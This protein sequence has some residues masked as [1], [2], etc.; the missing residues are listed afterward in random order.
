MLPL[1]RFGTQARGS[2]LLLVTMIL[3]GLPAAGQQ[4]ATGD[5]ETMLVQAREERRNFEKA[6]G[7]R[8]DSNHPVEK[9]VQALWTL[10]EES[11]RAPQAAKAASEAVHL[12][13]HADRFQAAYARAERIHP[14]DPAWQGLAQVLLEAASLQ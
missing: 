7:K 9:W 12:L 3:P 4:P 13:I 10:H 1:M 8:G 5:V 6:G 14:D 11:P 2:A